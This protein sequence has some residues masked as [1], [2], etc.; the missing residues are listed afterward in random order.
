VINIYVSG[1]SNLFGEMMEHILLI[2]DNNLIEYLKNDMKSIE[3]FN[4]N[5]SD[6]IT[7]IVNNLTEKETYHRYV[8]TFISILKYFLIAV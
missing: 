6:G 2:D 8:K 5:Y 1:L 3:K 7:D 4:L